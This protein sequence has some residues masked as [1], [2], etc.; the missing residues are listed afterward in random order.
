MYT[1]RELIAHVNHLAD[2]V[3]QTADILTYFNYC[4]LDLAE[5]TY[6]PVTATLTAEEDGGFVLPEDYNSDLRANGYPEMWFLNGKA[7]VDGNPETLEIIYN[8]HLPKVTVDM[9]D[10]KPE[11][12]ALFLL[13]Y[14]YYAVMMFCKVDDEN[15]RRLVFLQH[16]YLYKDKLQKH[17]TKVKRLTGEAKAW[18]IVR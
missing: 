16:Y 18:R 14:V 17:Y 9:L 12:P 4:Q 3:L 8:R 11:L 5:V 6:I 7:Y 15:E 1:F 13:A 10:S 2:D